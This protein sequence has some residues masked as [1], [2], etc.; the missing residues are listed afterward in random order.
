[1]DAIQ[2]CLP[3]LLVQRWREFPRGLDLSFQPRSI[4]QPYL[5]VSIKR[6]IRARGSDRWFVFLRFWKEKKKRK[7][8]K[9]SHDTRDLKG[10][11][12]QRVGIIISMPGG[13]AC[14][15]IYAYNKCERVRTRMLRS[16]GIDIGWLY[17]PVETSRL[18]AHVGG[19]LPTIDL[20]SV[21]GFGLPCRD[22]ERIANMAI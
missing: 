12:C 16:I 2:A 14:N 3:T 13:H 4:Q 20:P 17:L 5:A 7:E 15:S 18:H 10:R 22:A 19:C 8:K 6:D 11:R 1:M 9:G 21:S